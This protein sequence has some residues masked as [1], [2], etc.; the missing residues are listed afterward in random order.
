MRLLIVS[1]NGEGAWGRQIANF[2]IETAPAEWE[3][4]IHTVSQQLP[5]VIDEV[6]G[7]LPSDLPETD[8]LLVLAEGQGLAQ[9]LPDL[10]TLSGAKEVIAP[11][12]N[13]EWLPTGLQNQLSRELAERGVE[14][15]FPS[16]FCTLRTEHCHGEHATEFARH[17]GKPELIFASDDTESAHITVVRSAPCGNT[18]YVAKK[19]QG[20]DICEAETQGPLLHHYY[21]C[22]ASVSLIHKSALITRAAIG[23]AVRAGRTEHLR[24]GRT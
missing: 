4:A 11:V 23:K 15:V 2:V 13:E 1:Q 16:P 10:A 14:V 8:L 24:E 5:L 12:D 6:E 20:T 18:S 19:L 7:F 3:V 17:F 21:P 22:L 9:L